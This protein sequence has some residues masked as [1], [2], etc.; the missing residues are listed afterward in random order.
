[1]ESRNLVCEVVNGLELPCPVCACPRP[2]LFHAGAQYKSG[3]L[4][5]ILPLSLKVLPSFCE[6]LNALE[7]LSS[8]CEAINA[9]K[10]SPPFCEAM[11]ALEF[12]FLSHKQASCLP[13]PSPAPL[14]NSLIG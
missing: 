1:M 11:N 3:M 5:S 8:G 6:A 12:Y 10:S 13:P 7:L 14:P 4:L 9:L 2:L